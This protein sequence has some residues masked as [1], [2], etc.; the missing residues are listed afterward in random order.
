[1]DLPFDVVDLGPAEHPEPGETAPDFERPLVTEEYWEDVALSE[2]AAEG[3]VL[4]VFFPMDGGF[5]ATYLWSEI[6]DRGWGSDADLTVVGL[7][8]STPYEHKGFIAD[9]EVPYRLFSDPGNGVAET[10]GIVHDLDGMAGIS[11]PR[12]AAF[13][14]EP[15]RTVEY[16]WAAEEWPAFPDYDAVAAAIEDL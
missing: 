1:M 8:I 4:L 6:A 15:D 3:P 11:E 9:Q 5:P 12:P 7:S 14:L 13:L 2:I 16:A 10:Y